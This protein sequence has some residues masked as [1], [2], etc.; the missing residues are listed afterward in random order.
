MGTTEINLH[1]ENE[2]EKLVGFARGCNHI[3][4]YGA[5]NIARAI[6]DILEDEGIRPTALVVSSPVNRE[7][8]GYQ[9]ISS[10]EASEIIKNNDGIIPAFTGAVAGD[11]S[12]RL[13]PATP[14]M[15]L[16]NH[17]DI[18]ALDDE[19]RFGPVMNELRERF[20]VAEKDYKLEEIHRILVVRLDLIGDM[21]FTTPFLRELRSN[22][23]KAHI[24]LIV[25]PQNYSIV[26]GCPHVSEILTYDCP[27]QQGEL[28]RQCENYDEIKQRVENFSLENFSEKKYDAVFF[29]RELLSG[30]N[31][32]D[33]LLLGF[34]S[35]AKIRIGRQ[36]N[37]NEIYGDHLLEQV[38][39]S[40]SLISHH[41]MVLHESQYA[42]QMLRDIGCTIIN[43]RM[44][45]YVS[46][47]DRKRAMEKVQDNGDGKTKVALGIAA[48]VPQRMWPAESYIELIG[49]LN[50]KYP[51]HFVF[52]LFGGE[53]AI[54]AAKTIKNGL[55][56]NIS[57]FLLDF[58]GKQS[59]NESVALMGYCNLYVGSNTGLLHFASA[60]NI[61]SVTIYSELS[62][63]K[64]TDGDAPER[65]G[66]WM[67]PH[68]D[69][70]PPAG[71]D[72]CHGV[73]RMH[74]PHCIK[75]I[76]PKMVMRAVEELLNL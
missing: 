76:T 41:D 57:K 50:T 12:E 73:C 21:V 42:L 63:G 62:D 64:P 40:F 60:E 69:L 26:K 65:M 39:D 71:L 72:G 49:L 13:Y 14:Q 19:L 51:D 4:L 34:Y 75:L 5:G 25:R 30:R 23:E 36:L 35:E 38:S 53:D 47:D 16:I 74:F 9:V 56:D 29:P 24:T 44:E 70:V 3:Y 22:F 6:L 37:L 67:V 27:F 28:S 66:A 15:H 2:K 45:L 10:Q 8:Y 55:D 68:V 32:V 7:K 54:D 58:V 31:V 11:I 46:E 20:G 43:Q 48:S 59:L 18:L 17:L 33:E 1:L 61:P 52:L